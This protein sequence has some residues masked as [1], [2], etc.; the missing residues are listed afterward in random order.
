[1]QKIN[2]LLKANFTI[3]RL[4]QYFQ[5]FWYFIF[6]FLNAICSPRLESP[7]IIVVLF[8][9]MECI[10]S[11]V[12]KYFS[13]QQCYLFICLFHKGFQGSLVLRVHCKHVTGS[14]GEATVWA[15]DISPMGGRALS[16]G[17][18]TTGKDSMHQPSPHFLG[19]CRE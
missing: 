2:I 11:C 19:L 1:M 14:M 6:I 18:T 13:S 8:T 10:H 16:V 7:H 17:R 9:L 15:A 4:N 3:S 5:Q 12:G